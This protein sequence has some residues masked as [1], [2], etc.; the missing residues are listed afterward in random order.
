[1][2]PEIVQAFWEAVVLGILLGRKRVDVQA[3]EAY[4]LYVGALRF[5]ELDRDIR[6]H[7]QD[8]SNFHRATQINDS[9]R[10]RLAELRKLRQDPYGSKSFRD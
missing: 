10:M 2:L 4:C 6:F 8:V 5:F 7:A 9:R 1:M 3:P